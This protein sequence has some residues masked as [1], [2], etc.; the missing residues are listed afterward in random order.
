MCVHRQLM[1]LQQVLIMLMDNLI[2]KKEKEVSLTSHKR[3]Y[4]FAAPKSFISRGGAI[5]SSSGS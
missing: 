5:G 2:N 3:I 4:I 1:E